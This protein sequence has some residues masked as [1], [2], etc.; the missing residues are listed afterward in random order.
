M[1]RRTHTLI[2]Y[3]T[4]GID[5]TATPAEQGAIHFVWADDRSETKTRHPKLPYV[6]CTVRSYLFEDDERI[7][8]L[9]PQYVA[10]LLH[11]ISLEADVPPPSP[12]LRPPM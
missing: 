8:T 5:N 2:P 12:P 9:K 1:T 7:I 6:Q 10:L 4:Q 3:N 11:V